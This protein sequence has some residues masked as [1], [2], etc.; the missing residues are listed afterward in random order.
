MFKGVTKEEA[1]WELLML[2]DDL[3]AIYVSGKPITDVQ[4]ADTLRRIVKITSRVGGP[5]G[6]NFVFGGEVGREYSKNTIKR[7]VERFIDK[8]YELTWREQ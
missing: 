3:K 8:Y 7:W 1:L 2:A 6:M 5:V 4:F